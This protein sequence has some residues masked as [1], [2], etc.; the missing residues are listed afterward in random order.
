MKFVIVVMLLGLCY[1]GTHG[2]PPCDCSYRVL[3]GNQ[4]M[5]H[6]RWRSNVKA[7]GSNSEKDEIGSGNTFGGPRNRKNEKSS[8][9]DKPGCRSVNGP[10]QRK[11]HFE[12]YFYPAVRQ[13]DSSQPEYV[14]LDM[15]LPYAETEYQD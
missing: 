12:P 9:C 14:D 7:E 11:D 5:L 4:D 8:T 1:Y 3:L 6:R 10:R 13:M 2:T 15:Q